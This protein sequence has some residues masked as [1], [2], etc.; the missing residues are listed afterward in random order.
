MVSITKRDGRIE[1]YIPEKLVVSAIKAGATPKDAREIAKEVEKKL[2]SNTST[3]QIRKMVL[4][5]LRK[6][7]PSWEENWLVYDRAVKRI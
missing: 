1:E 5:G 4:E 3:S 7:N 2:A 6:R